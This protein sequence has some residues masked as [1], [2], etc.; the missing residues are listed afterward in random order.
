MGMPD[1]DSAPRHFSVFLLA[2]IMSSV[3]GC[4]SS[5]MTFPKH[6]FNVALDTLACDCQYHKVSPEKVSRAP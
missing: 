1:P 4:M 2:N 3:S 6:S 5:D